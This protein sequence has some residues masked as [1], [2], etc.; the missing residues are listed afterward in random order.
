MKELIFYMIT[1]GFILQLV[2]EEYRRY[3]ELYTGMILILVV[4]DL[5]GS[6]FG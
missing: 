2:P 6:W 4:T 1:T 3:V 5:I